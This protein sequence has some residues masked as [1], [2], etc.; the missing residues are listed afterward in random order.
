MTIDRTR[1]L[2]RGALSILMT[3]VV[4][5]AAA[6]SPSAAA[7]RSA[8]GGKGIET[9]TGAP[10]SLNPNQPC[11]HYSN[12]QANV[13]FTNPTLD[14]EIVSMPGTLWNEGP[15]GTYRYAGPLVNNCPSYP[16]N[17]AP[18]AIPGFRVTLAGN[19]ACT[20]VP[21]TYKRIHISITVA[22]SSATCSGTL[23]Y[24]LMYKT[25]PV[26]IPPF[27]EP[28][29]DVAV[30]VPIIAPATCLIGGPAPV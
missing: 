1:L 24:D 8:S 5:L 15:G 10:F 20:N 23:Q 18:E 16:F 7:P 28:G 13:V 27:F 2:R 22:Y 30:C 25:T 29:D 11:A 3:L 6:V 19:S 14:A 9:M 21:A 4:V 12:Y 17:K 26:A